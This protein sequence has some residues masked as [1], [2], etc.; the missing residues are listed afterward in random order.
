MDIIEPSLC[1]A[2]IMTCFLKCLLS[3]YRGFCCVLVVRRTSAWRA[4]RLRFEMTELLSSGLRGA[5]LLTL[6][7]WPRGGLLV[8]TITMKRVSV[9]VLLS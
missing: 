5:N 6:H 8:Y 9:C 3:V 1:S 4:E 7:I 2:D